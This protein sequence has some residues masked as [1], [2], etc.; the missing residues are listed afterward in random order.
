MKVFESCQKLIKIDDTDALQNFAHYSLL[1]HIFVYQSYA[2]ILLEC[3]LE[4]PFLNDTL[5]RMLPFINFSMLVHIGIN[6]I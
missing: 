2:F 3:I 4:D 5:T 1:S 6:S